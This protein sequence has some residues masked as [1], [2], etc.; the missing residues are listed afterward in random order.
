MAS[1]CNEERVEK[2][3]EEMQHE[4]M[5]VNKWITCFTRKHELM[6]MNVS[7]EEGASSLFFSLYH[8]PWKHIAEW[9]RDKAKFFQEATGPY[10]M[11]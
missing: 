1:G 10:C 7:G 9:N 2:E 4:V 6:S 5:E 11:C 3:T 8:H